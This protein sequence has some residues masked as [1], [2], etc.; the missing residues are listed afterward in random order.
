M[1]DNFKR[2][3]LKTQERKE[4]YIIEKIVKDLNEFALFLAIHYNS[5]CLINI[6]TA[7]LST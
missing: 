6:N 4:V 5:A 7:L 3:I 2:E 1:H